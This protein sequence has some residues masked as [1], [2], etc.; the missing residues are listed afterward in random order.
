MVDMKKKTTVDYINEL[1]FSSNQEKRMLGEELLRRYERWTRSTLLADLLDF[2]N[3][4][5]ENKEMIGVAQFFGKFRA[6]SFE[7]YIYRLLRTKLDIPQP[8]QVFWGEK[9]LIWKENT[10]RYGIE[11]DVSIGRKSDGFVKPAVAIDAKVELDS[12]RLKTA[13]ASMLLVKR[14]NQK[15]KCFLVY[16]RKEV[17]NLLLNAANTWIDGIFQFGLERNEIANFLRLVQNATQQF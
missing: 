10:Q 14:L 5:Q 17:A 12:A 4:I 13:L 8:M 3:C 15:T 11:V 1:R 16:I 2:L 9:C 7:E 6:S